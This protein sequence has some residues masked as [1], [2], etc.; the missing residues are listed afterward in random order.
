MFKDKNTLIGLLLI[1]G[2]LIGFSVLN[3]PSKEEKEKMQREQDSLRLVNEQKLKQDSIA[4]EETKL[5]SD[6]S[7]I[8][9]TQPTETQPANVQSNQSSNATTDVSV[10]GTFVLPSDSAENKIF[11]IENDL[12]RVGIS[13][14]GGKIAS[15]ELR[16]Y[17][18]WDKTP[19]MFFE[20]NLYS[21]GLS[22]LHENKLVK[23]ESLMFVP[24]E[25]SYKDT[26][27]LDA[28]S[29]DTLRFAMRLYPIMPDSTGL[30]S[31]S[32]MEFRYSLS[33]GSYVMGFDIHFQNMKKYLPETITYV[34]FDMEA[35][36][37]Q[38]EK[39]H[40]N[41]QTV[42]TIYYGFPD[43]EVDYLSERKDDT[44]SLQT[45]FRWMSFKQQ[46]FSFALISHD[47]FQAGDLT[48]QTN[49]D[50]INPEYLRTLKTSI[51]IPYESKDSYTFPI[52]IYAGPNK[53]SILREMDLGLER[54]IPLGWSF[55]LMQW[56]NRGAVLPV[57]TFLESYGMNYGLIILILTLLLKLVLF[58]IAFKTYLSSARM[59]VL[60]PDIEELAK[61]FPKKEDAMKKQQA[62]ME[63]YK[64]AGVNPMAGCIPMLLQFPILIAMFRFFPASIELRQKA[65]LWADDLSSY[66]SILELGFEIP[67]YGSHVSLF[68]L[69]MTVSTIIYTR[70]NSNMMSGTTQMPGMKTML[71]LMP[72]M[73]LG[74]FNSFSSALSYYYFLANMI[75]FAQM[76]IFNRM[77][78]EDKIR[79]R[80][81]ENKKK[82]VKKSNF[83]KRLEELQKQQQKKK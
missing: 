78:D 48:V 10:N 15:L 28:T 18:K 36:L 53:Y 40:T 51:A 12:L 6:T 45:R 76:A 39:S 37:M 7:Q 60:K 42:T 56:I 43:G 1:F 44:Q 68:T 20:E 17:L 23:T 30:G 19:L 50:E 63:L 11:F 9:I 22:F 65:F 64:K 72:I 73:F 59:K 24:A 21:F 13:S 71:Y 25:E 14:I 47:G 69:L 27:T 67:F 46:F 61:K 52:E 2:I 41:E 26:L 77:I 5:Q 32:Y 79:E 31:D 16:E 8:E 57:F 35:D 70:M 54:Q 38:Q 83:A 82:P 75:T 49:K 3:A 62:T 81:A 4:L 33:A 34:N 55:F 80:I 66:D 58:P 29:K 74:F